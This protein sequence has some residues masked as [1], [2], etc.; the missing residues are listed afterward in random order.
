MSYRENGCLQGNDVSMQQQVT[1]CT[2][3]TRSSTSNGRSIGL[4][5]TESLTFMCVCVCVCVCVCIYIY[6]YNNRDNGTCSR[7]HRTTHVCVRESTD[8]T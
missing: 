2:G 4:T 6:I 1:K 8:I 3:E 7:G 5:V